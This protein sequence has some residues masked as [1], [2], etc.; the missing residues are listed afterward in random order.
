[1]IVRIVRQEEPKETYKKKTPPKTQNAGFFEAESSSA[2]KIRNKKKPQTKAQ[3]KKDDFYR[4][5]PSIK[6]RNN[7]GTTTNQQ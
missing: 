4:S 5:N 6:Q 1:M 2:V 3:W 7:T